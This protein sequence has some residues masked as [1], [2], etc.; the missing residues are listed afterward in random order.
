MHGLADFGT[1]AVYMFF[2][3]SGYLVTQS[4][5]KDP[6]CGRF[7]LRRSL[8]IFPG[9]I[10]VIGVSFALLGPI[11][12]TL[13]T[14]DY[15]SHPDAWS[16]L[17]RILIYPGQHHLPGVFTANPYAP[18]AINGS[19]WSLRLEVTFYIGLAIIG[20]LGLLRGRFFVLSIVGGLLI[21]GFILL[22][23][24]MSET[25]PG[26]R[27]L[28]ISVLN[29]IPF[30]GGMALAHAQLSP[31]QLRVTAVG[32]MVAALVFV[33][34]GTAQLALVVGLTVATLALATSLVCDLSKMGDYSYG[35]YIWAFP[36]QQALV[37]SWPTI[38]PLSLFVVAGA[39]TL[40]CAALSWHLIEKPALALKP[41]KHGERLKLLPIS[42]PL[43]KK[44]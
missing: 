34:L 20:G 29:A 44:A 8:R 28:L 1:A 42:Q 36:I 3:I 2:A 30:F 5:Q 25:L 6:H 18:P 38:S 32:V 11:Y 13:A 43:A 35:I 41:S 31:Q 23:W 17:T 7:L 40:I 39:L 9:L 24:P 15:F 19:L 33:T 22:K 10:C 37:A 26:Y 4:W 27:I 16:Y 14:S 21:A 12:S